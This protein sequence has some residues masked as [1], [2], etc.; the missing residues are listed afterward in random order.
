MKHWK[1][2]A[3]LF[4][5]LFSLGQASFE[6]SSPVERMQIGDQINLV[7][8]AVVHKNDLVEWSEFP[9]AVQSGRLVH[10]GV[11]DSVFTGDEI[12]L[13]ET[14][15]LTSF[16]SGYAVVPPIEITVNGQTL[17]SDPILI[18]VDLAVQSEH[19]RDIAAP[20]GLEYPLWK[21][22]L[23]IL[24]AIAVQ[25]LVAL[26]LIRR[27]KRKDSSALV[28]DDRTPKQ[29]IEHILSRIHFRREMTH[30]EM[31]VR[32]S[33]IIQLTYRLLQSEFGVSTASGNPEDWAKQL[34]NHSEFNGDA[35]QLIILIAKANEMR[36]AGD[37][38]NAS[39]AENWL[40]QL[41]AWV[42][43][44]KTEDHDDESV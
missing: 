32:L 31:D 39:T 36:F 34:T 4:A 24:A 23:Y 17:Q 44:C 10:R 19:Y 25:L 2:I 8:K 13:T 15:T 7:L 3:L 1:L 30:E 27:S 40:E 11:M 29:R 5:P 33:K 18:Q 42:A 38:I 20:I 16:D 35:D 6:V 21:L 26:I 12:E 9:I 43:N 14:W 22:V 41:R 37:A 28:T